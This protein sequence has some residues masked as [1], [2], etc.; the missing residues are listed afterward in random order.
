MRPT[1]DEVIA[2]VRALLKQ[3]IA[4][5]LDPTAEKMLKRV[6]AVLRDGR[7]NEAAFDL[8]RENAAFA[9]L[10]RQCATRIDAS[11]GLPDAMSTIA[12]ALVAAADRPAAASFVEA[13]AMNLALRSALSRFIEQVRDGDL[14]A[15]DDLC[16]SI[17]AAMVS[18]GDNKRV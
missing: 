13:N 2:G 16:A 11:A 4:P 6:M 1:P 14:V 17:G 15:L 8:L 12:A 5:A 10:A 18:L 7:W 9:D 3:E